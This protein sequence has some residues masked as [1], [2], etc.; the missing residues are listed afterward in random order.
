MAPIPILLAVAAVQQ[1]L[2]KYGL[3]NSMS[4]IA[5]SGEPREVMH[6]A[7]LLGYGATAV[8]PYLAFE[9]IASLLDEGR[10]QNGL[11]VLDAVERY[12][13]AIEKGLLKILSKMGIST[14]RS[15]RGA[16]IFESL[17]LSQEFIDRYFTNTPSRLG[18]IDIGDVAASTLAIHA[19]AHRDRLIGPLVL[20]NDGEYA[21]RK[22]GRRH[23]WTPE[24]ISYL[25]RAVKENSREL[26]NQFAGLINN[27]DGKYCTLRGLM[28]FTEGRSVPLEEVEPASSIVRRFVT[29]A[30]SFGSISREAHQ[31]MAQ[32]MNR[33][34]GRSNS[35][36]GG[37]DR[38]RYK[39]L[40]NGDRLVS[41]TKQVASGRFGVT[42]EYLV[43]ADEIQIKIAQGGQTR[44][45]RS[46][47]GTQGQRGN[48][49]GASFHSGRKSD[50][51]A[52]PP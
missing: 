14:L 44:R 25:Q 20:P 23:M 48:R 42:A 43:N 52:A 35:G 8:N 39:P 18:G 33:M 9:T 28:D 31:T 26:Y 50:I 22:N 21:L 37:E 32:A 17:G 47:P 38:A 46:A 6:F 30:M 5:E 11:S 29:G 40:P 3:R 45:G 36:E 41:A 12:I 4:I 2:V 49:P 24:A 16:Q 15:Y 1:H 7:L 13:E 19:R 10:F 51:A 34:G 27:Q